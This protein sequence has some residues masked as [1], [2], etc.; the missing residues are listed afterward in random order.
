MELRSSRYYGV[1]VQP[2]QRHLADCWPAVFTLLFTMFIAV[3]V[4]IQ[5]R[6]SFYDWAEPAEVGITCLGL[7]FSGLGRYV[8]RTA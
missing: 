5:K 2:S 4:N 1:D 3:M 6:S 7:L 8:L